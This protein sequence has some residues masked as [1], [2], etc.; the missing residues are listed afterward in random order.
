MDVEQQDKILGVLGENYED[1]VLHAGML[2][3]FFTITLKKDK[4]VEI[5]RELYDHPDDASFNISPPCAEFIIRSWN[6]SVSCISF[7]ICIQMRGSD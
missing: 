7:T 4:I 1:Q 3:D 2:Y 5:I 6:K